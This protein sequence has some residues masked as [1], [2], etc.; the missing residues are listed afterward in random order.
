M[1]CS[2]K[3]FTTEAFIHAIKSGELTP[4]SFRELLSKLPESISQEIAAFEVIS[5]CEAGKDESVEETLSRLEEADQVIGEFLKNHNTWLEPQTPAQ[6]L[7]LP[8]ISRDG[9]IYFRAAQKAGY[10]DKNFKPITRIKSRRKQTT[11]EGQQTEQTGEEAKI[12]TNRQL[13][14]L[15]E[16]LAEKSGRSKDKWLFLQEL[17]GKKNLGPLNG[18]ARN[19]RPGCYEDVKERIQ[20]DIDGVIRAELLK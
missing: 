7:S 11:T 12:T 9:L 14:A 5:E 17:W 1:E 6:M 18:Y 19:Y 3:Q 15:G 20:K 4:A 13:I 10:L 8:F 16:L 2:R